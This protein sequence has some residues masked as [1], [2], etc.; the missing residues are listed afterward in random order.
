M[1]MPARRGR[2][3]R[4]LLLAAGGALAVGAVGGAGLALGG[5]RPALLLGSLDQA[6]AALARLGTLAAEA[7]PPGAD[8][9][10]HRGAT[11][12][13]LAQSIEYSMQGFPQPKPLLFQRTLGAAAFAVFSARGHMSHDLSAP[14]PGATALD[15]ALPLDAGLQ[16]LRQAIGAFRGWTGPLQPHF[17][18]GTLDRAAYERAHAMHIAEHLGAWGLSG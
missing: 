8:W 4:R 17:A 11:L 6:E 1:S 14:I 15:A 7:A 2:G 9:S 12:A 3:R 13:H 10:H 16:R 18:Y 5:R